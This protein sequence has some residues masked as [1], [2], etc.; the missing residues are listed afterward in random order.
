M[1]HFNSSSKLT[2]IYQTV[3]PFMLCTIT[4]REPATIKQKILACNRHTA[5]VSPLLKH[6]LDQLNLQSS[7]LKP[8]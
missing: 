8:L 4:F 1:N 2:F 6:L 3:S 7:V 5:Y